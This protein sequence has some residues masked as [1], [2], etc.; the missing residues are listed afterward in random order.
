MSG[1]IPSPTDRRPTIG[2]RCSAARAGPGTRGASNITIHNFLKEQPQLNV[3]H[4]AVQDALLDVARFWLER[5]VDGFRLD[6]LNFTMHDPALT[7]NPPVAEPEQAD[8][9]VRLSASSPQPVA[10]PRSSPFL[11][12]HPR[13]VRRPWRAFTRGRGRRRAGAARDDATTPR[14]GRLNSAYGFDFLYADRLTPALVARARRAL[15]D[16]PDEG[17]PS[18]A[19]ENHDAPRALSR[20]VARG[21]CGASRGPKML[22]LVA[23]RGIVI[24]YQG[25]ELGLPQVEVPFELL[26]DPEAIA[27]WPQTLGRDGAR[28]PMPW[29]AASRASVSP[30]VGLAAVRSRPCRAE[31]R[32]AGGRS[33]TR[34][35]TSPARWS[36]FATRIRRCAGARSRWSRPGEQLLVFERVT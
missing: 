4:P 19:F 22:L 31:R 27:N 12:R 33:A 21:A 2:S 36:R 13:A 3:H 25:E 18:W 34:C 1:P 6:A 11:E 8:P 9:A 23:L 35:C 26:Q 30:A 20:W 14:P 28:T 32:R 10:S 15:A 17:W 24:L 7:D 29:R 5:G 16:R